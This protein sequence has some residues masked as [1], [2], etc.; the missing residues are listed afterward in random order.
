MLL[1]TLKLV[2]S[3]LDDTI[4]LPFSELDSPEL[5]V[6]LVSIGQLTSGD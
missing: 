1:E 4:L 5:F 6:E 2:G 3:A